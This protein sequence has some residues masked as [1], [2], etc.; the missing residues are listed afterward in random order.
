[1]RNV[2]IILISIFLPL[3][4]AFVIRMFFKRSQTEPEVSVKQTRQTDVDSVQSED[5]DELKLSVSAVCWSI[6]Q[7]GGSH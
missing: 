5:S 4:I 6:L 2:L 1:M 3:F 7:E